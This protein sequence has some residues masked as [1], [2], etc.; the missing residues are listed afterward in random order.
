MAQ[1]KKEVSKEHQDESIRFCKFFSQIIKKRTDINRLRII[2]VNKYDVSD[3]YTWAESHY[4]PKTFNKC[5]LALKA[6]FNYLIGDEDVVMKNPFGSY[7]PKKITPNEILTLSQ[8]E[9]FAIL[10]AIDTADP[11]QKLGGTG[12]RK[13]MYKP[14]LKDGFMLMLLTGGRREE[15]V[16][17]KWGDIFTSIDNVK[18]FRSHN[19]KVEKSKKV[20]NIYKYIP[21]NT[22]LFNLLENLGYYK[23]KN[24][25]E[26]IFYPERN[27]STKT[28]MNYLSKAFTHYKKAA[29]IEKEVSMKHLRKTYI[30]WVNRVLGKDTGKITSH[31]THQVLKDYYL[32]PT[33]LSAIEKVAL[34]IKIFG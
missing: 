11:I 34:E 33:I 21:I 3:F 17:L 15:V 27:E 28:I 18:F 7:I 22:D 26:Y 12:K 19:L 31:S 25:N 20:R 8:K 6:F 16:E 29:G 32:D 9:F 4:K 14:Y 13:N 1:K 5:M 10:K 30:S 23:N 2:D 24:T